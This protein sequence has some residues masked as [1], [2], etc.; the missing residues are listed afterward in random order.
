MGVIC[1]PGNPF[2]RSNNVAIGS[3][4]RTRDISHGE[5]LTVSPCH[6]G[7]LHQAMDS[8]VGNN[9]YSLPW[10]LGP[11]HPYPLHLLS[12]GARYA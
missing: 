4:A 10:R 6:L 3:A 11:A 2:A 5:I 9:Y 1:D 12:K 8:C 7:Y